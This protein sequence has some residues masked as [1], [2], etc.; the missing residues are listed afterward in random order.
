MQIHSGLSPLETI[1]ALKKIF[2]STIDRILQAVRAHYTKTRKVYNQTGNPP[3]ETHT[4]QGDFSLLK[5][6]MVSI[7]T[8]FDNEADYKNLPNSILVVLSGP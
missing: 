8:N 7:F 5:W 2:S 6:E 1:K 3:E 4:D